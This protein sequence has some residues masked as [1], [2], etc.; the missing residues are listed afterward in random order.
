MKNRKISTLKKI[1][2]A[3]YDL[4]VI[5]IVLISF[6]YLLGFVGLSVVEYTT[7]HP[8][9]TAVACCC[10]GVV[11]MALDTIHDKQRQA[12]TRRCK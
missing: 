3:L 6:V 4:I 12:T 7:T 9:R 8:I 1:F 11:L 5:I 10:F 2:E